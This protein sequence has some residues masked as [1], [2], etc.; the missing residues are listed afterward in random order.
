MTSISFSHLVVGTGALL[1]QLVLIAFTAWFLPTRMTTKW[2]GLPVFLIT[3]SAVWL[4]ASILLL[5]AD[6][7][8][9]TDVPGIGYL[10]EGFVSGIVGLFVYVP[11]LAKRKS[12][13]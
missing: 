12:A 9:G 3:I 1:L 10:G 4:G 8:L 11:R 13:A 5:L 2:F 7:F 6:G